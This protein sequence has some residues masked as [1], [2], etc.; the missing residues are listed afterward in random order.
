MGSGTTLTHH[1][2][3]VDRPERA[4]RALVAAHS[5]A[6]H[7]CGSPLPGRPGKPPN[8]RSRPPSS[9]HGR[10]GGSGGGEG[11]GEGGGGGGGGGDGG[12]VGGGGSGG[13]GSG[14]GGVDGGGVG[15][16]GAG[17]GARCDGGGSG[18]GS[19]GDGGSGGGGWATDCSVAVAAVAAAKVATVVAAVAAAREVAVA[20][21][22]RWWR[23][24]WQRWQLWQWQWRRSGGGVKQGVRGRHAA[25]ASV[26]APAW[27]AI[28]TPRGAPASRALIARVTRPRRTPRA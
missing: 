18:G 9:C 4:A 17:C 27:R 22:R 25:A 2:G 15:G 20:R 3:G 24:W 16:G 21:R 8:A 6:H 13:G 10:G 23:Q 28:R 14:S 7:V 26:R 1:L 12:E 11:G 19:D 5:R